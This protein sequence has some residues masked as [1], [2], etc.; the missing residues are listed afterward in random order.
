MIMY[1]I[2]TLNSISSAGIAELDPARFEVS[3]NLSGEEGILVRS[4]K[5]HD[6]PFDDALLAIAR[7]GAGVNN[8]PIERCS[9]A[10]IVV[11]NT[12]G[13]NANAVKELTICALLL[14]SRDILGGHR[15]VRKQAK[16]PGVDVSAAV[17]AGKSAFVGPEVAGKTLGVIG[18]GAIGVQVANTAV[19]MGMHVF[20]YDPFL[21][22]DAAISMSSK[23]HR[24]LTLEAIYKNCDYITLHVPLGGQTR[25]MINAETIAMMK[26]GV[27]ILNLAR[28]ELVDD[29]AMKTALEQEK[30]ACYITDFPNNEITLVKNVVAIPHLGASSPESEDN[31]AIMAA[32]QLR[33][34]LELGNI[35][36]SVNLPSVEQEWS[37]TARLCV[38]HRNIPA[39]LAAITG[40][41]SAQHVNVANLT[42]KSKGDYAYTI[43]DVDSE[44]SATVLGEIQAI[45]GVLRVRG[46]KR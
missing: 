37:G 23:V 45:E 10:G 21:S 32:R 18:L 31:C 44:L 34:Y 9:E 39:M 42:N 26:S 8:I 40:A 3:D 2:K 6:Q 29:M 22:V 7:A 35:V 28:G 43:V 36:N 17:E 27:R 46:I 15:W 20:G 12:P 25:G 16:T 5:M 19:R 41:L 1:R 13:A 4:A 11:F 14:A 30:V 38:I 24:A 33:D